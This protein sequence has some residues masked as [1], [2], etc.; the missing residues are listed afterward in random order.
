MDLFDRTPE[1][2]PDAVPAS[3]PLADRMRPVSFG[4]LVGQDELFGDE[5]FISRL[6]RTAQPP[7][8]IFWGP[9]GSGKTTV[10]RILSQQYGLP[11]VHF[12]A[13]MGGMKEVR[14]IVDE[15]RRTLQRTGKPTI[16]FVDEI[17]RFNKSQQDAFLPHVESGLII[18]IGATTEN[19][20]FEINAA[21]LSRC[22]VVVFQPIAPE[23]IENLIDRALADEQRGF[24]SR[25]VVI[26]PDA[27]ALIAQMSGGDARSALNM[28]ESAVETL[29]VGRAEMGVEDVRRSFQR[30][31]LSYDKKG[32]HH[33]NIISAFIKSMRGTDPDAAIYWLARM[34]ESGEDPLFIARRMVIFASEDI[35]N[36]DPQALQMA[37]NVYEACER[38]GLPECRINL[39]HGVTYLASAPKSNASYAAI[40]KAIGEVKR[41]GPLPVPLHLRNAPT[42]LMREL[43]YGKGYQYAHEADDALILQE[44][45]PEETG[46]RVF[47]EPKR[48]GAEK[49]IAERLERIAAWKARKRKDEG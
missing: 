12:S 5:G 26:T 23:D 40:G 11:F 1:G 36:A 4:D 37:L 3:R 18:L 7:S 32:E 47:Y 25:R 14:E 30:A 13:V 48:T 39:A 17:H 35:G 28:L 6:L 2:K 29:P 46:E 21:L 38:I 34:L 43:G 45:L 9:P 22:R 20:S 19:P 33:Y 15:A 16:L 10:A 42:G 27:R 44:H 41:S 8:L 24:G 31:T 49:D